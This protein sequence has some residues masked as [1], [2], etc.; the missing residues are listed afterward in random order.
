MIG[1]LD[2]ATSVKA[3][4]AAGPP[5]RVATKATVRQPQAHG[6][7]PLPARP[8]SARSPSRRVQ[9]S[10]WAPPGRPS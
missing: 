10:T 2:A 8:A 7:H 3:A 1:R 6:P 4:P 9:G 5:V